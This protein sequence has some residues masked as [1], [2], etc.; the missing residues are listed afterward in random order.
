MTG[1]PAYSNGNGRE[2][3]TQRIIGSL[4]EA[5]RNLT[6]GLDRV[7]RSLGQR[8]DSIR[9]EVRSVQSQ[10]VTI[11]EETATFR[12]DGFNRIAGLEK[13]AMPDAQRQWV[14]EHVARDARQDRIQEAAD[15]ELAKMRRTLKLAFLVAVL[16]PIM[17]GLIG[18]TTLL[19]HW[20]VL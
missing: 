7:E 3:S 4:E 2:T 12:A 14:E 9:G 19:A 10:L 18:I 11:R 17:T 6:A 15:T 1:E 13:V 5:V 16:S 8:I 20:K